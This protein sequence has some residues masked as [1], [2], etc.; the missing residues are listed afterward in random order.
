MQEEIEQNKLQSFI[1]AYNS[2]C[3]SSTN[4][5]SASNTTTIRNRRNGFIL[6]PAD[7][8]GTNISNAIDE[9][10]ELQKNSN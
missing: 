8:L 5:S 4:N 3:S 7:I 2:N 10:E 1:N 6:S 9:D